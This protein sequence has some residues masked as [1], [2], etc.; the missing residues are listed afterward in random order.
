[1]FAVIRTGG[2]QYR[3]E[4]GATINV[5]KLTG[6]VGEKVTINDVLLYANGEDVRVGSPVVEGAGVQAEIVSHKRGPKLVIFKK[7]RRHGKQLKKGHR[8]DQ[9]VLRIKDIAIQ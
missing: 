3:V 8:Q 7:L 5:E 4:P 9:T 1:M 2:K 6:D